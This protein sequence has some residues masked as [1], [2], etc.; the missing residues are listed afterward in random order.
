MARSAAALEGQWEAAPGGPWEARQ[1]RPGELPGR[2]RRP[3]RAGRAAPWGRRGRGPPACGERCAPSRRRALAR[4]ARRRG[5]RGSAGCAGACPA[6]PR[7][8]AGR[9]TA[10]A[11]PPTRRPRGQPRRGRRRGAGRRRATRRWPRS[12][13]GSAPRQAWGAPYMAMPSI[14]RAARAAAPAFTIPAGPT[15]TATDRCG[16]SGVP[17][18]PASTWGSRP[19]APGRGG[20]RPRPPR[21][22]RSRAR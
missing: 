16:A 13:R 11:P 22:R 21:G 1:A 20:A 14:R 2:A 18:G 5:A 19:R 8:R 15:S 17:P 10:A 4:R 3:R 9:A 6:G 12:R 7:R